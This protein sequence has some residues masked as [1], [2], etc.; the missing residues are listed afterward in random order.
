[1]RKPVK[2]MTI[3]TATRIHELRCAWRLN[4]VT[5][6]SEYRK[7]FYMVKAYQ[8]FPKERKNLEEIAEKYGFTTKAKTDPD[9]INGQLLSLYI[10]IPY[11]N[12]P[13]QNR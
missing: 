8:I 5:V 10:H 6:Y 4:R 7:D 3:S 2:G 11:D 13:S 12:L 9:A 1:M